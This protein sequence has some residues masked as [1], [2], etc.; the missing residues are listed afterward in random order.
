MKKRF[1]EQQIIGFLKQ[2]EAGMAVNRGCS[3]RF[4]GAGLREL[5]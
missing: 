5:C 4:P 3:C 2:A 1:T